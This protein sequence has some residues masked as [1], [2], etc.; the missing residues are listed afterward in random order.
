M[1]SRLVDI[2]ETVDPLPEG[3][4]VAEAFQALQ[5]VSDSKLING[6]DA[7][8]HSTNE[9]A[10]SDIDSSFVSLIQKQ[11]PSKFGHAE[12]PSLWT[13]IHFYLA[14]PALSYARK[15]YGVTD[16][17][18]RCIRLSDKELH[19]YF[20][21][22]PHILKHYREYADFKRRGYEASEK[23]WEENVEAPLA[24]IGPNDS[25][26]AILDRWP[27]YI[28][29]KA[30]IVLNGKGDSL[31]GRVALA[32]LLTRDV[33]PDVIQIDARALHFLKPIKPGH[34]E[35]SLYGRLIVAFGELKDL[36]IY[37]DNYQEKQGLELGSL[38]GLVGWY[39]RP[40]LVEMMIPGLVGAAEPAIGGLLALFAKIV[41]DGAPDHTVVP[42]EA[43]P[44]VQAFL[45]QQSL[46]AIGRLSLVKDIVGTKDA[47]ALG[48]GI[49]L[50]TLATR[51]F[52]EQARLKAWGNARYYVPEDRTGFRSFE[53]Y[54]Q[55]IADVIYSA[56]LVQAQQTAETAASSDSLCGLGVEL[57]QASS[58]SQM[59]RLARTHKALLTT[60]AHE[61][62]ELYPGHERVRIIDFVLVSFGIEILRPVPISLEDISKSFEGSYYDGKCYHL[63]YREADESIS[64][65]VALPRS[66][67][68]DIDKVSYHI[69]TGPR[70]TLPI[71]SDGIPYVAWLELKVSESNRTIIIPVPGRGTMDPFGRVGDLHAGEIVGFGCSVHHAA[72]AIALAELASLGAREKELQRVKQAFMRINYGIHE[73]FDMADFQLQATSKAFYDNQ[74]LSISE[75]L[76]DRPDLRIDPARPHL[77]RYKKEG[78]KSLDWAYPQMGRLSYGYPQ[79]YPLRDGVKLDPRCSWYDGSEVTMPLSHVEWQM[80]K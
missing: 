40:H 16:A 80:L 67:P 7:W 77:K 30:R 11:P 22:F 3:L 37:L 5:I 45:N 50:R 1:S 49:I 6:L 35:K 72:L 44:S 73:R 58:I 43:L 24:D 26:K 61:W 54:R 68:L 51:L 32:Y 47:S 20:V 13:G 57:M 66:I 56:G 9:R 25:I 28:R 21:A 42:V 17:T 36:K 64:L 31:V 18:T 19:T 41:S 4:P 70:K 34:P 10:L 79:L 75:Y 33:A 39:G 69:I 71:T 48:D 60:L 74:E 55:D 23:W 59:R 38:L 52:S 62:K 46:Q 76:R 78:M 15:A 53:L 29:D 27:E 8:R 14:L 65:K 63:K 12:L 2:N